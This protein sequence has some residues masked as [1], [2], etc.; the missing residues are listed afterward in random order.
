MSIDIYGI[1]NALVDIEIST[2]EETLGSLD[3]E[4]G[5][6][7]LIDADTQT[8]YKSHHEDNIRARACGGS[9]ANTIIGAAQLGANC[10]YSCRVANDDDGQFYLTDLQTHNVQTNSKAT[11]S[12]DTGNC[13]VMVTPDADRTLCTHLGISQEFGINDLDLDLLSQS[14]LVYIEG[15]LVSSPS[16]KEA[17]IEARK[18]AQA[19]K[20]KT[21]F[22]FSDPAMVQF[23]KDG[24]NEIIGDKIDIL[25]CNKA[26]SEAFTDSTDLD[27]I[28][29]ALS[30]RADMVV[31]TQGPSGALIYHDNAWTHIPGNPVEAIDSNG[32]GDCFAGAFL[33]AL[34]QGLSPED[35]GKLA[36][37]ASSQIVTQYGPRLDDDNLEKVKHLLEPTL[38]QAQGA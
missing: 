28:K 16:G 18:Q 22:T 2:T 23:F 19:Q 3:I 27:T 15:Y 30:A 20:I 17:A 12:G 38:R 7:T 31:I 11:D 8:K 5:I 24:I 37:F 33:A 14:N 10:A 25:F 35:A 36:V 34:S 4:K 1:G 26:E 21:A 6:M 29:T 9:A 32:A 13:L